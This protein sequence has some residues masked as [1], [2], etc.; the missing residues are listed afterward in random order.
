MSDPK[1]AVIIEWADSVERLLPAD[2]LAITIRATDETTRRLEL[3]PG[4]ERSS[5]LAKELA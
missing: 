3:T 1:A 2:K 4:G 5:V